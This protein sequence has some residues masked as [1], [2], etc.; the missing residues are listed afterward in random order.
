MTQRRFVTFKNK[1]V[2]V[3]N[4]TRCDL[5]RKARETQRPNVISG[6]AMSFDLLSLLFTG[7]RW[8][9]SI[10]ACAKSVAILSTDCVSLGLAKPENDN[11]MSQCQNPGLGPVIQNSLQPAHVI[12]QE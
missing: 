7:M 5:L 2:Q 11:P 12:S 3:R 10:Y 6:L 9:R 8:G 1:K 4:K